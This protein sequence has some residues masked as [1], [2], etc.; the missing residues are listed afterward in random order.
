MWPNIAVYKTALFDMNC[1]LV[2]TFPSKY[3]YSYI[4]TYTHVQMYEYM[5]MYES[6]SLSKA[7]KFLCDSWGCNKNS[8]GFETNHKLRI[9]DNN[10]TK[11]HSVFFLTCIWYPQGHIS[12][13]LIRDRMPKE[14]QPTNRETDAHTEN[15]RVQKRGSEQRQ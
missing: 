9:T 1:T 12:S 5:Y 10:S 14:V 7:D 11:C 8:S 4:C 15:R 3:I 13:Q 2:N 6:L